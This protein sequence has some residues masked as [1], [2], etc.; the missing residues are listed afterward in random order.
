MND[1]QDTPKW[2]VID[3]GTK[4]GVAKDGEGLYGTYHY[5]GNAVRVANRLNDEDKIKA[6]QPGAIE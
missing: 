4:Y 6:N 5:R 1:E 2:E 3:L